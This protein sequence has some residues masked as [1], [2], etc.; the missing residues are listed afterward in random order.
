MNA[1][2]PPPPPKGRVSPRVAIA[3]ACAVVVVVAAVLGGIYLSIS[4][5]PPSHPPTY[6]VDVPEISIE[7]NANGCSGAAGYS[8]SG[9]DV[10]ATTLVPLT[11]TNLTPNATVGSCTFEIAVM[12]PAGFSVNGYPLPLCV[13]AGEKQNWST[14]IHTPDF[15]YT[16]ELTI[17]IATYSFGDECS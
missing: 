6:Y 3:V 7:F 4:R 1:T 15:S 14:A 10:E 16:G 11:V 2:S 13:N 9:F 5:A 17:V 12:W 8:A